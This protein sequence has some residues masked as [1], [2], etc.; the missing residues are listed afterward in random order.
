MRDYV[1]KQI[2]EIV[3]PAGARLGVKFDIDRLREYMKESAKA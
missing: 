1:V 2:K 3:I